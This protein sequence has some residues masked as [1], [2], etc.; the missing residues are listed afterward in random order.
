[1]ST[2]SSEAAPSQSVHQRRR[3]ESPWGLFGRMQR[4][5]PVRRPDWRSTWGS[6]YAQLDRVLPKRGLD[7]RLAVAVQFF[8][9]LRNGGLPHVQSRLAPVFEDL[10]AAHGVF[11]ADGPQR[12]ELEARILARQTDAQIGPLVGLSER[13]VG[14]YA[15]MFFDVRKRLSS[16]DWILQFAIRRAGYGHLG[17]DPIGQVWRAVGYQG[18]PMMLDGVLAA[19]RQPEDLTVGL[20]ACDLRTS[21]GRAT[22]RTRLMVAALALDLTPQL[23]AELVRFRSLVDEFERADQRNA[24]RHSAEMAAAQWVAESF[25]EATTTAAPVAEPAANVETEQ[26][27][28][29]SED[30][31]P[32]DVREAA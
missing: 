30:A 8:R 18:G 4:H 10:S 11:M 27:C 20:G 28:E 26:K 19:V 17:T 1:M 24:A 15:S 21:E 23:A 31:V 12:A 3:R 25:R 14:L 32:A 5:N 9:A 13:A 22:A 6:G 29:A 16:S 2:A 7:V